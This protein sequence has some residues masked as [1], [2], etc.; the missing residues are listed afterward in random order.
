MGRVT[1]KDPARGER[2]T[3]LMN[4]RGWTDIS[5]GEE[6]GV[7]R[8]T[9]WRWRNGKPIGGRH[10]GPLTEALETTR[11]WIVSGP[12]ADAEGLPAPDVARHLPDPASGGEAQDEQP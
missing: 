2:I 4:R 3:D 1:Q 12:T 7:D 8:G 9:I 10:V 6:V 5:L 11:E